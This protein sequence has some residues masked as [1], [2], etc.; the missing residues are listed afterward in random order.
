[1]NGGGRKKKKKGASGARPSTRGNSRRL[2]GG[3]G[4]PL[5]VAPHKKGEKKKTAG[6]IRRRRKAGQ[7]MEKRNRAPSA[8]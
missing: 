3:N 5:R 8:K 2:F 6:R 7:R 1:V 4:E